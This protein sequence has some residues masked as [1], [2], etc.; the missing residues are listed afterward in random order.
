MAEDYVALAQF[1]GQL[2]VQLGLDQGLHLPG[3]GRDDTE[4]KDINVIMLGKSSSKPDLQ[5]GSRKSLSLHPS[6]ALPREEGKEI[7]SHY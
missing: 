3:L 1:E 5:S 6:S 2:R 7:L 4:M